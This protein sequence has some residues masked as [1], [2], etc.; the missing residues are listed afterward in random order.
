[1]QRGADLDIKDH[2]GNTAAHWAYAMKFNDLAEFLISKGANDRLA[3]A[4]G[5]TCRNWKRPESMEATAGSP[6]VHNVM[7]SPSHQ[8]GV[9]PTQRAS[10]EKSSSVHLPSLSPHREANSSNPAYKQDLRPVGGRARKK[11]RTKEMLEHTVYQRL[12]LQ[13]DENERSQSTPPVG[14]YEP[15]ERTRRPNSSRGR[16]DN[17]NTGKGGRAFDTTGPTS[18]LGGPPQLIVVQVG[19]KKKKNK[20]P[21]LINPTIAATDVHVDDASSGLVSIMKFVRDGGIIN[22]PFS[23]EAMRKLG[24]VAEQ[25]SPVIKT[26]LTKKF[27]DERIV[28][29]RYKLMEERRQELLTK[30]FEERRRLK[31]RSKDASLEELFIEYAGDMQMNIGEFMEMLGKLGLLS[32]GSDKPG[33]LGKTHAANLF[34]AFAIRIGPTFEITWEQFVKMEK[35]ISSDLGIRSIRCP[36]EKTKAKA[37]VTPGR[38]GTDQLMSKHLFTTEDRV[39]EIRKKDEK[40]SEIEMR[41]IEK[42]FGRVLE[43]RAQTQAYKEQT[44][45]LEAERLAR[46][47]AKTF[48]LANSRLETEFEH[49][50][51]WMKQEQDYRRRLRE[52]Q[53]RAVKKQEEAAAALVKKEVERRERNMLFSEQLKVK[54]ELRDSQRQQNERREVC[55]GKQV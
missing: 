9:S 20:G 31:A 44:R 48:D 47:E 55:A 6:S 53:E 17:E 33:R 4:Q 10:A 34:K 23:I 41:R 12:Y 7:S 32:E 3:N 18:P 22:E 39:Q 13:L 42:N 52:E 27:K 21:K 15:D 37:L 2:D 45:R 28:E 19:N 14:H 26:E 25:L 8:N 43:V 40:N 46:I 29:L 49:V 36:E 38:G 24:L 11:T 51:R 1:M 16:L 50:E 54:Q 5:Y 35:Q 30:V